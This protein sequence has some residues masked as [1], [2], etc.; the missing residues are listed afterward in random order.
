MTVTLGE[1]VVARKRIPVMIE[2]NDGE[3]KEKAG[4]RLWIISVRVGRG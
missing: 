2:Y 3:T 4:P 1:S